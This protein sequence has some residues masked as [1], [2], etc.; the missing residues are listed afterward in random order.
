MVHIR[1][2][3]VN[4]NCPVLQSGTMYAASVPENMPT[5]T[6]ITLVLYMFIYSIY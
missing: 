4:D 5:G 3:D 6:L 1:C 2:V